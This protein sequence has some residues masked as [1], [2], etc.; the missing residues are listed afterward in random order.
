MDT[1]IPAKVENFYVSYRLSHLS[2]TDDKSWNTFYC[3]LCQVFPECNFQLIMNDKLMIIRCTY[4][5]EYLYFKCKYDDPNYIKMIGEE[6][7][8]RNAI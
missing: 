8:I 3:E 7:A 5:G 4:G 2:Y 6:E 1:N